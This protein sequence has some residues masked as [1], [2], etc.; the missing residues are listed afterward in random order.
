MNPTV[1]MHRHFGADTCTHIDGQTEK[2]PTTINGLYPGV[3]VPLRVCKDIL[4][5]KRK[6]LTSITKKHRDHFNLK[7]ALIYAL[8]KIR[9]RIEVLVCQKQPQ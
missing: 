3:R 2:V 9:P 8:T 4:G 1:E 5:G 7:P 6:H